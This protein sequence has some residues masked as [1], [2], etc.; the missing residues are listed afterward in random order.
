MQR[1]RQTPK[2]ALDLF[3]TSHHSLTHACVA[4]PTRRM[5]SCERFYQFSRDEIEMHHFSFV[6][7]DMAVRGGIW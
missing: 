6:R 3:L 2:C 5:S 4:D 1:A 7:N